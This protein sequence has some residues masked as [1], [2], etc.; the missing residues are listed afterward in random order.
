VACSACGFAN[1]PS[2]RFC[3]G[4]GKAAAAVLAAPTGLQA[5]VQRR[6]GDGERKRVT[7]L[8]ADLEGSTAAIEGLDPEAALGRIEPAVQIMMRLVHRY[9]GV[10]CRRL[11]D[12]ILALFGAP[13][14]HEDHAVRACFA[15]L[16]IQRELRE[17]GVG[18]RA[19]VGLNSGEVLYRTITSDLGIEVDVVGP[20]VHVAARMEQMAPAGSVYFTG[21]TQALTQ[22]LI[23]SRDLGPLELKGA[24]APVETYE[25]LGASLYVSRWEASRSRERAPFVGREGERMALGAALAALKQRHGGVVGVSGES[26]LGKSRLV[27]GTIGEGGPDGAHKALFAAAT[28]LGRTI[29]YHALASALRDLFG[30]S[31]RDDAVRVHQRVATVLRDVDVSLLADAAMFASMVSLSAA[32]SE[33]LA[34]DPHRK[35]LAAREATLRLCRRVAAAQ[36][37]L[38]VIEDMHWIDRDSEEVLRA[39]S[40]LAREVALLVVLTYRS[41][42]DDSWLQPV[43]GRRLRIAPLSDEEVRRSL[44]EWFVEAPETEQLIAQLTARAG[45]NP[46]F[47][48]ECVRDLTQSGALTAVTVEA[49]GVRRRYVCSQA[50]DAIRMPPSVHDVIAS[51]IDRRSPDC[52]GLLQTLSMIDGR[53]PLWLAAAVSGQ[54]PAAAEAILREA[55]AAEILVQASLY[56]EVE[57]VF[58]HALLRE[59]AHDS[60]TRARRIEAHRRIVEAVESHHVERPQDHEEMLAYHAPRGELWDKAARYQ[61]QAAE[62]ALARGSYAEAIAGM[63]AALQSFHVAGPSPEGTRRAID[64]LRTLRA[65]LYATGGNAAETRRI[66]A[67]AETLALEVDDRVRLGWVRADQSAQFWVEGANEAAVAAARQALEIAEQAGEIRL[68]A[69]ALFRLGLGFYAVGNYTEAADTLQCSS[70]LLAGELRTER[71]GTAGATSVIAAGYLVTTLCELGRFDEAE[72][73]SREMVAAGADAG[74]VYSIA[75]AQMARC[76]LAIA[77][78]VDIASVLAPLEMLLGAVKA[79][80]ALAVSQFIE[81]LLGRARY[82]NGDV[83][84]SLALLSPKKEYGDVPRAHAHGLAKVWLAETLGA[85][86]RI[87]EG[88]ATL[89]AVELGARERGERGTLAHCWKA[90]G[91]LARA[92]GDL[93]KAEIHYRRSLAQAQQLSMV[94]VCEA[95]EAALAALVAPSRILSSEEC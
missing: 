69:L 56:P 25:A 95:C 9:E 41:E 86:R 87:D 68:R 44:T 71:I 82:V 76:T 20:V 33:W 51:R 22:G 89:D 48:E 46:L 74:D 75:A 83:A 2:D 23:E 35:R 27:H 47:V 70:E 42:Y 19:R 90:R 30:I 37:L 11:G 92:A 24:S 53:I 32:T 43:G 1:A 61:A 45:G 7:V 52:V 58:A 26:G 80:G 4:C 6:A 15:A 54:A 13:V 57:Y 31:E 39:V 62:R 88:L 66:L 78:A 67:R 28:G 73:L 38:L 94:P 5:V 59:V 3:G 77:R 91:E 18:E 63:Y 72:L 55:V 79:A 10:V 34:M 12:G 40:E 65:L 60:L 14:A 16:G 93:V 29:P 81:S 36:P 85:V 49:A 21:E 8:F 17:A 84:G 50:P 64:Q